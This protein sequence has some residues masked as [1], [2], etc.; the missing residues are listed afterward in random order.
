MNCSFIRVQPGG[1]GRGTNA[2]AGFRRPSTTT[3]SSQ[4][5]L[6]LDDGRANHL[7]DP[8]PGKNEEHKGFTSLWSVPGSYES[9]S[10]IVL[11]PSFVL[12]CG[13]AESSSISNVSRCGLE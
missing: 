12:S 8:I 1:R 5:S 7:S 2:R 3:C 6:E 9:T 13:A 4:H 11:S 10:S